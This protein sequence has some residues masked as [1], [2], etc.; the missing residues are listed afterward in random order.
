MIRGSNQSIGP[1]ILFE[2]VSL[3]YKMNSVFINLFLD[4]PS[5]NLTCLKTNLKHVD[6]SRTLEVSIRG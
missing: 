5:P 1:V 3:K 4:E 2:E 6:E